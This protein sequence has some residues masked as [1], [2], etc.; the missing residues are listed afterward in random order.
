MDNDKE[1]MFPILGDPVIKAIP[2]AALRPHE[3]QAVRNHSQSLSRLASRGGLSIEEAYCVLKDMAWPTGAKWNKWPVRVALMRL[4]LDAG[5]DA[6][7]ATL[8]GEEG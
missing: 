6:G 7:R 4:L 1:P 5:L 8:K 3:P 2:W